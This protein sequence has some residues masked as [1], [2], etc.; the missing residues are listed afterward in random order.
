MTAFFRVFVLSLFLAYVPAGTAQAGKVSVDLANAPNVTMVGAIS[1]WDT[2][3][4]PRRLVDPKAKLDAPAVDAKAVNTGSSL[5]EFADLPAGKYDLVILAKDRVRIEGFQYAPVKQ[6][7]P[8]FPAD[9]TTDDETRQTILDDIAKSKH[10][11]NRVVPLHL[12]GDEKAIRVLVMLI[13]DKPTSYES[14]LPGAA[15]I[16]HEMWQYTWN[17]GA[18]QKERR[19]RVI[20]RAILHRDE[21][22]KWTWLWDPK[23]GGIQVGSQPVTV[24]YALPSSL[25]DRTL[26]GLY[27]Y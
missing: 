17:Y 24:K 12:G 26:K 4:S 20:D 13:R 8:F 1:R 18:W 21:L 19:T 2:D 22:R 14:D 25:T 7:D 15:T 16:R 11:E 5:W 10:Y 9:A 3:G 23:L 27:P 6:F